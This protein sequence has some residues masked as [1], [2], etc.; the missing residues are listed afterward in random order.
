VRPPGRLIGPVGIF[1]PFGY[2]PAPGRPVSFGPV[3]FLEIRRHSLTKKDPARLGG[4]DLS[5][6]GVA[7]AR[8]VGE[9]LGPFTGVFTSPMP[10]TMETAIAMGQAVTRTLDTL[11]DVPIELVE[12]LGHYDRQNERNHFPALRRHFESDGSTRRLGLLQ[13]QVWLAIAGEL[14]MSASALIVSHG[15]V[16][17]TGLVAAVWD[18]RFLSEAPFGY[19]EGV[20]LW[21]DGRDFSRPELLRV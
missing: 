13:R 14:P 20:R 4:S 6:E 18:D 1:S 11:G 17:E 2:S 19:C 8:R 16:I 9:G 5:P 12:E 21:F 7:L 15:L 3:P 10:R